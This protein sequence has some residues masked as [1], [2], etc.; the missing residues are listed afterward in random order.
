VS[1]PA[2]GGVGDRKGKG[3]KRGRG[4]GGWRSGVSPRA[5]G[6]GGGQVGR[7]EGWVGDKI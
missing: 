2:A 7:H 1:S 5:G 4:E 3:D 6:E